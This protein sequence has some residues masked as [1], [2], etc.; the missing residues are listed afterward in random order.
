MAQ[1]STVILHTQAQAA[2]I[3]HKQVLVGLCTHNVSHIQAAII[4]HKYQALLVCTN[5]QAAD[6]NLWPFH[7]QATYSLPLLH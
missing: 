3:W 6:G 7:P 5:T 2:I 4:W 1:A